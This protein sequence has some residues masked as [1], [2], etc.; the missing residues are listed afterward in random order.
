MQDAVQRQLDHGRDLVGHEW[1]LT[2]LFP[3]GRTIAYLPSVSVQ[4]ST[5]GWKG[6]A[7][8]YNYFISDADRLTIA[9]SLRLGS[10]LRVIA[11]AVCYRGALQW[12][13]TAL[14]RFLGADLS[15]RTQN[16]SG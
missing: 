4:A 11:T 16:A 8:R 2:D 3:C 14:E 5:A 9:Y 12:R 13:V 15:R 6:S 10:K 1:E 7:F